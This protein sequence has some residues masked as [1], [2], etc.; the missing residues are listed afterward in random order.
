MT[1]NDQAAV[2]A[3]EMLCWTRFWLSSHR[4]YLKHSDPDCG[5][6]DY[7]QGAVHKLEAL[8]PKVERLCAEMGVS[9]ERRLTTQRG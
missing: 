9:I 6:E 2:L 4:D 7:H 3:R 8:E 5:S 1:T